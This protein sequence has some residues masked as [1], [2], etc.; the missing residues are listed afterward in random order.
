MGSRRET[1]GF[2]MQ[3]FR[4]MREVSQSQEHINGE[5]PMPMVIKQDITFAVEEGSLEGSEGGDVRGPDTR[6]VGAH[7]Q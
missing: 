2:D 7:A 6:C 3:N 1:K 4:R 5:A